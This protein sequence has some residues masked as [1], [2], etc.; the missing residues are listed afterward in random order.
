MIG[1]DRYLRVTQVDTQLCLVIVGIVQSLGKQVAVDQIDALALRV[2]PAK[3][4]IN[5]RFAVLAAILQLVL[6][7]QFPFPDLSL[8]AVQLPDLLQRLMG[9][10]ITVLGP[11][12]VTPCMALIWISR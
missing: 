9:G 4:L 6:V 11:F 12:K 1:V 7:S 10:R 3:E 8:D 2:N 5:Q